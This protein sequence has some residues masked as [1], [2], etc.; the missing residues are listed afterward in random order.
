[1]WQGLVPALGV[2]GG[3]LRV[4]PTRSLLASE[5]LRFSLPVSSPLLIGPSPSGPAHSSPAPPGCTWLPNLR[6][7]SGDS[8]SWACPII[9]CR[10]RKQMESD[11][12]YRSHTLPKPQARPLRSSLLSHAPHRPL[13]AGPRTPWRSQERTVEKRVRR[14]RGAPLSQALPGPKPLQPHGFPPPATSST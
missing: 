10:R 6:R 2:V 11:P 13:L 3:H 14:G 7:A 12:L 8:F 1:M 9:D 5:P 4:L